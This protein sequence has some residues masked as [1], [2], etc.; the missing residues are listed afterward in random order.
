MGRPYAGILGSLVFTLVA[1]RGVAQGSSVEATI[2]SASA[3]SFVFAAI[4]FLGGSLAEFLVRDSVRQQF[5]AAM[6]TWEQQQSEKAS[7]GT[8]S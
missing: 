5:Q 2:L 7:Q 1:L 4:G 6:T 8:K 3:A